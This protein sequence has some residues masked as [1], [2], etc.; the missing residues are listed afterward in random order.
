MRAK[1][2]LI[3]GLTG[4]ILAGLGGGA[5]AASQSGDA[6]PRQA[7]INDV[8]HRLNVP[9]GKLRAA[10]R[11][12]FLDRLSAAVKAGRLTQAQANE[13]RSRMAAHPGGV[14]FGRP[15]MFGPGGERRRHGAMIAA[16]RYL[17]LAPIELRHEL[18]AGKTL[19]QIAQ[20]RGKS[21]T[22]LE[23]AVLAAVKARLDKAVAAK[24][25]TPGQEQKM[26]A[27][28]DAR[29]KERVLHGLRE[30]FGPGG[31]GEPGGPGG[32][33]GPPGPAGASAPAGPPAPPAY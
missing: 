23:Q 31:P 17:G 5:Y 18:F 10:L 19:A 8:A 7:F 20:A 1:R 30:R 29:I 28:A 2:K 12:A 26:L 6:H 4:L 25:I 32:P 21:V 16:A 11:A 24:L 3:I 15:G 22:G 33:G 14:P 13:I 27:A 9:P